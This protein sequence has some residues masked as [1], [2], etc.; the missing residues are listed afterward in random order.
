M[1][2]MRILAWLLP[3][4]VMGA[5]ACTGPAPPPPPPFQTTV[6]MKD[7]MLNVLD[8][9]ADGLWDSVGT[10]STI[11]GVFEK[12][13]ATDDEWAGVR[14]FAIQL[15]ESGN[16]L[17]LPQRSNGSTEWV[18]DAQALITQSGRAL[19]AIEAKDKD[20]LFTIGGDIYDVCTS[21]HS[22]FSPSLVRP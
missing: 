11:E 10:I 1:P 14:A 16:L 13:P 19:K 3:F 21:C 18:A 7:L 5:T 6:N 20:A 12:F 17:M 8:P 15:A 9:A 4:A 22:K 2:P